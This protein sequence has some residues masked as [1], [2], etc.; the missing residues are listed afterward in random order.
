[1]QDVMIDP[2]LQIREPIVLNGKNVEHYKTLSVERGN[3]L[4][5]GGEAEVFE[6]TIEQMPGVYADKFTEVLRNENLAAQKMVPRVFEFTIVKDLEHPNLVKYYYF[7]RN[8]K[9]RSEICQF[10][11]IIEKVDG[12]TLTSYVK[13]EKLGVCTILE[14]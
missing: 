7:S 6:C 14:L 10:H 9:P 3:S 2:S 5:K 11:T 4:G 1:M 12:R 8:Y 13:E